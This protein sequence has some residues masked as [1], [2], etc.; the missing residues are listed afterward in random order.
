MLPKSNP[1]K[2]LIFCTDDFSH[3]KITSKMA[4]EHLPYLISRN[5]SSNHQYSP[6]FWPFRNLSAKLA[7][8]RIRVPR[9]P[10]VPRLLRAFLGIPIGQ[11]QSLQPPTG[12]DSRVSRRRGAKVFKS[13]LHLRP[14]T[15]PVIC[16]VM[17]QKLIL[18]IL[19]SKKSMWS[20]WL[21]D[22]VEWF[23]LMIVVG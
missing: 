4:W 6:L 9:V 1:K 14:F 3:P 21:C 2:V 19:R 17:Y 7:L 16:C 5:L 23:F 22:L 8:Y 12:P 18:I 20:M 15:Y 11:Y 13:H 10:R